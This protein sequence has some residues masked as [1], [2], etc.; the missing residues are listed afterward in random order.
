[1]F[2]G[3]H[4][5]PFVSKNPCDQT[6][7]IG[8]V[9]RHQPSRPK[10]PVCRLQHRARIRNV[11]DYIPQGDHVD[12]RGRNRISLESGG[13]HVQAFL[14]PD[15]GCMRGGLNSNPAPSAVYREFQKEAG[16][17]PDVE[18]R[19]LCCRREALDYIQIFLKRRYHGLFVAIVVRIPKTAPG[20]VKVVFG[21]DV[22]VL[23]VGGQGPSK[24]TAAPS[25]FEDPMP[26]P[27]TQF[28]RSR[29]ANRTFYSHWPVTSRIRS[30]E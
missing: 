23:S 20:P 29:F 24:K 17:R 3:N 9:D 10:R 27:P 6:A 11:F 7:G 28:T 12:A 5:M 18:Q 30:E 4:Q 8:R 22:Q 16:C 1:M 21:V 26:I 14:P 13:P 19:S 25:T 2:G 15:G